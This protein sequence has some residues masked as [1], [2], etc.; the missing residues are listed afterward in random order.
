MLHNY[1]RKTPQRY[2][3]NR[4]SRLKAARTRIISVKNEKDSNKFTSYLWDITNCLNIK[5]SVNIANS[6]KYKCYVYI[7]I[8]I[9]VSNI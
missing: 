7:I 3:Y 1:R 4:A 6:I 8:I 2:F 9:K 5:R